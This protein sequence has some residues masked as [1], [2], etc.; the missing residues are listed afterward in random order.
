MACN[1]LSFI[2]EELLLEGRKHNYA[3]H[4]SIR[5]REDSLS[6]ISV[7]T[8]SLLNVIPK[9]TLSKLAYQVTPMKHNG[10]VVKA[11]DGSKR[12][13][14]GE[15]DFSMM[16]G[17]QVFQVTFQVMDMYPSYNCLLGIP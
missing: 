16:I 5:Y 6:N 12:T 13:I 8:V 9:E 4:I 7:D 15:L 3:L 10:V 11:I 14:I 1:V 2:D 17:P